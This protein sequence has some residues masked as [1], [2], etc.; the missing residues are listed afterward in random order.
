MSES[1]KRKNSFLE[2]L[3]NPNSYVIIMSLIIIAMILTWIVPSGTF[4]R[5]K[6][7]ASGRTVI[8][9]ESFQL[10]ENKTVGILIC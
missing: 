6:D 7:P 10:V 5:V 3:K 2:G 8:D 4:E 1:S 9:P